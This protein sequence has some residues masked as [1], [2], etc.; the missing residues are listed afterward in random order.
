MTNKQAEIMLKAVV[1]NAA[2]EDR[3]PTL[4]AISAQMLK[5]NFFLS[6]DD[7]FNARAWVREEL[8]MH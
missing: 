6:E 4:Y 5:A 8:E 2:R 3:F 1:E 7:M